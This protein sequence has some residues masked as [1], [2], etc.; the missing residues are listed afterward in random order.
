MKGIILPVLLLVVFGASTISATAQLRYLIKLK[1]K[2]GSSYTLAAP[3]AYLS[4]R[5]I[6]RRT[7]YGIALDSTDLPVTPGYVQQIE[8]VANV[9]VLN[10]SRWLNSVS[11][12]ISDAGAVDAALATINSFP[13]VQTSAPIAARLMSAGRTAKDK[14]EESY[15]PPALRMMEVQDNY[16]SYGH[17][18]AQVRIHHGEFLHNIGLRGLPMVIGVIDAGFRNYQTISGFDTIR[19]NNRV[20]GTWDFVAG[21]NNVND[22]HTH[23]TGVLSAMATNLPGV[24]VGTAPAASFYLYRTEDAATEYPIEEHNW[25][26]AAERV[27]SAGGDVINSSLGYNQFSDPRYNYTY[28]DMNGNTTMSATGA[29]LAAKKGI[30]VINAAGNS[31]ADGW[32][33]ILTPADADSVL[34]VGNVGR[35]SAVYYTSSYGPSSDGQVKPDVASVGVATSLQ[36]ANGNIIGGWGTSFAAPNLA[37]LAT[38]LWEGFRELNNMKIINAL[39]QAGHKAAAPDDRVGYGIPDMKKAVLVLLKDFATSSATLTNCK[40]AITWTSKDVA[41]MKYEIERKGPGENTYTKV[42]ERFGTGATFANQTYTLS[43]TT[44]HTTSGT[45]AYRIRQV[46]DTAAA[47]YTADY[48]DTVTVSFS[49]PCLT[50]GINPVEL[51]ANTFLLVPNPAHESVMVKVTTPAPTAS[52]LIQ[53]TNSTGQVVAQLSRSKG[54]GLASIPVSIVHLAKGKYYVSVYNK[55]VL[56]GTRELLKL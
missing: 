21:N 50:T 51:D 45:I 24:L 17:A 20:L 16:Y 47:T 54:A 11:I 23:G 4:Q 18:L 43:D 7:R 26:C 55:G 32:K 39:R 34:A 37:G 31:G 44:T 2:G 27:D 40:T 1:N 5:S 28:A 9:T 15:S 12:Q 36:D 35:D 3:S 30:L 33:Y 22:D 56:L 19:T 8:N 49:S 42:A 13:F 46:I 10:T 41:A 6:E 53:V 38:C 48:I 14:L 25:V 29:D 52:L